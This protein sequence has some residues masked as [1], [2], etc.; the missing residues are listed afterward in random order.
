[1]SWPRADT[2]KTR[3]SKRRARC[4]P[5]ASDPHTLSVSRCLPNKIIK[6]R[7]QLRALAL[8]R[9]SGPALKISG[10]LQLLN[11]K[12]TVWGKELAVAGTE[13]STGTEE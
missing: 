2:W 5:L 4:N 1:M 13:F 7:Q 3:G 9:M 11:T 10:N 12:N 6:N 8:G